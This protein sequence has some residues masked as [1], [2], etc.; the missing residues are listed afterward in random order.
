MV[1]EPIWIAVGLSEAP[2]LTEM[3]VL[4]APELTL[5][6]FDPVTPTVAPV[7][8]TGV[9]AMIEAILTVPLGIALVNPEPGP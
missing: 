9:A 2:A 1:M 3:P 8:L 6:P 4:T 7:P 5:G